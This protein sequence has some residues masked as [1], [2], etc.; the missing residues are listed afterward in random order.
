MTTTVTKNPRKQQDE[1]T[2]GQKHGQQTGHQA[3]HSQ[4]EK[5]DKSSSHN[6]QTPGS[7][8]RK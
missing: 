5:Q 3:K 8:S 2:E 7:D 4:K 6:G 1:G